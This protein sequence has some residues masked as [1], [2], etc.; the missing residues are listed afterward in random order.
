MKIWLYVFGAVGL[1]L[2]VGVMTAWITGDPR[3]FFMQCAIAK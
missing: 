2:T 3:C 1:L